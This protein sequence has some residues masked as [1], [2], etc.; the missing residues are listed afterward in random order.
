MYKLFDIQRN[1]FVDGPGIRTTVFFRGCNLK[2]AWCHNPESQSGKKYIFHYTDKCVMCKKCNFVCENGA[3]DCGKIDY[4]KCTFCQ[5]C[6]L[7]CPESALKLCGT[8]KSEDELFSVLIKDKPYYDNSGG[9]VTFSGGECMLYPDELSK[10]LK[11]LKEN[12][13][14]TAVDTAGNVLW[15]SFEKVTESTDLFLYDIKMTDDAK[16]KKY[17][18]VS[19]VRI[20]ENLKRLFN[21]KANVW[22]RVPV[23][24]GINDTKE[25]MLE[26]KKFLLPYSPL[27]TQLLPY[28]RMGENKYR[29]LGLKCEEFKVPD[30]EKMKE[31]RAV[32]E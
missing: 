18:G 7:M 9:G 10:I 28:H 25:D 22:I 4:L 17:T 19:N 27:E 24:G 16:H 15:E 13:I 14:H 23:I 30:E 20:L 11:R 8:E 12:N 3:I 32:F 5:K 26:I 2:C 31:L 1:S 21:L 29:A 6:E